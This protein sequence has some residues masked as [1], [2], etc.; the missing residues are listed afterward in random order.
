MCRSIGMQPHPTSGPHRSV[1]VVVAEDG[2][3]LRAGF[4]ALLDASEGITVVGEAGN[5][6]EAIHVAL[7]THPDVVMMDVMMPMVDG[8]VATRQL[9]D[10]HDRL[11]PAGIDRPRVVMLTDAGGDEYVYEAL[12]EGA[13]GFVS[14]DARP[15]EL[16]EAVRIAT[17]D[18]A[19]PWPDE[20]VELVRRFTPSRIRRPEVAA[21]RAALSTGDA[22]VVVGVGRGHD[23][24]LIAANLGIPVD[25]VS[26]R[27]ASLLDGLALRDRTQLVVFAYESGLITTP[28]TAVSSAPGRG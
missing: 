24:A 3:M 17:G 5:G 8:M 11:A 15:T 21:R 19:L 26:R 1:R 14:K 6:A 25:E 27:V 18:D 12:R 2:P 28:R 4:V 20:V 23:D 9:L 7:A 22:I 16:V 13:R 10:A